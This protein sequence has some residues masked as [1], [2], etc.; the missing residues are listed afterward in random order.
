ML[1]TGQ[2]PKK[3]QIDF[4]SKT[5]VATA[6]LTARQPV[7]KSQDHSKMQ[8]APGNEGVIERI[9]G[10]GVQAAASATQF[11]KIGTTKTFSPSSMPPPPRQANA[12]P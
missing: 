2:K 3:M 12:L 7:Q 10:T 1:P 4:E 5:Q 9:A 6:G 11:L 8:G